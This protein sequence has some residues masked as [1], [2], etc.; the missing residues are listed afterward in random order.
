MIHPCGVPKERCKS[1]I[2]LEAVEVCAVLNMGNVRTSDETCDTLP[3][4]SRP[5]NVQLPDHRQNESQR[6]PARARAVEPQQQSHNLPVP[7]NP[8]NPPMKTPR[9][10]GGRS[11]QR[12]HG[13][14]AEAAPIPTA[15]ALS[16]SR[17]VGRARPSPPHTRV[18]PARISAREFTGLGGHPSIDSNVQPP[19][20]VDAPPL[21]SGWT[22]S[23][24]AILVREARR[25]HARRTR[26]APFPAP[27]PLHRPTE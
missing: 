15:Q 5:P 2:C 19:R 24:Q 7:H 11:K 10:V 20:R 13:R 22:L 21:S 16:S 8:H 14:P 6:N 25:L 12:M 17:G 26:F 3:R 1:V 23:V 27:P 4:H 18:G 9:H